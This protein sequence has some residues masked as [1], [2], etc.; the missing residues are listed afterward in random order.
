MNSTVIQQSFI[1]EKGSPRGLGDSIGD[2]LAS[3][4]MA[5]IL[6]LGQVKQDGGSR[7]LL[8]NLSYRIIEELKRSTIEDLQVF[9]T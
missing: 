5:L 3:L 7:T 4:Q 2:N 8:A 6:V 1:E 9:P